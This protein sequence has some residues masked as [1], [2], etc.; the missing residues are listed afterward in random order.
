[1]DKKPMIIV[2]ILFGIVIIG[3]SVYLVLSLTTDMFKNAKE[4]FQTQLKTSIEIVNSNTDMSKEQEFFKTLTESNYRD[5]TNIDVKYTNKNDSIENFKIASDGIINNSSKKAFEN[6]TVLYGDDFKIMNLEYLKD[7]QTHGILFS[8]VVKKFVSV[9]FEKLEELFETIGLDKGILQKYDSYK[10][11]ELLINKKQALENICANYIKSIDDSKF[12]KKKNI[13]VTLNSGEEKNANSYTLK[14]SKDETRQLAIDILKELGEQQIIN[15]INSTKRQFSETEIVIYE[16]EKKAIRMTVE[17]ENKQ[18]RI[19]FKENGANI[20]Y[21]DITTEE[22]KTY[23]IDLKREEAETEIEYSDSYNNK[24]NLKYSLSEDVSRKNAQ[25]K[26]GIQNAN[27]KGINFAVTKELELSNTEIEGILK[28]FETDANINVS[29]LKVTDRNTALNDLLKRIDSAIINKNNQINS[30]VLN[31]CVSFNKGLEKQY[32]GV[33]EQQK[34]LFNNQFLAYKGK[35]VK[36]AIIFNL[37]ELVGRNMDRYEVV[38]ED[39]FNI[40]ISEGKQNNTAMEEIK[41]KVEQSGKKFDIDFEYDSSGK[42]NLMKIIG[43]E[44]Q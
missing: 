29:K 3:L 7:N 18:I 2:G 34:K 9:D 4:I 1:M 38:G 42:V 19:D 17:V 31:I 5:N 25:I 37:L 26:V 33:T 35:D 28:S 10:V 22:I 20:K 44:E 40:V 6:I 23:N 41:K 12:K 43:Y 14:L 21:N 15:E 8:D 16:V 36:K 27:V 11:Y 39:S 24:I 13:Q 30:E 32:N